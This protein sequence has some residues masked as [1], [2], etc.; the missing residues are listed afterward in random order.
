MTSC[1]SGVSPIGSNS[2]GTHFVAGRKRVPIPAAGMTAQRTV[3]GPTLPMIRAP[4]DL[5]GQETGSLV[6][7][8]DAP[9][10]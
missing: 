4:F 1:N 9:I 8:S 2:L 5:V 6:A 3:T 10:S 7:R